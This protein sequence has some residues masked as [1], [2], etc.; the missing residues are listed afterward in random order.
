MG[1]AGILTELQ[2]LARRH[3]AARPPGQ[4]G[5][6]TAEIDHLR[7]RR[8]VTEAA[9][10]FPMD[11]ARPITQRTGDGSRRGVGLQNGA[12]SAR[13]GENDVAGGRRR[14]KPTAAGVERV[15]NVEQ[16]DTTGDRGVAGKGIGGGKPERT[17]IP[18]ETE[19]E[20]GRTGGIGVTE[21]GWQAP[22]TVVRTATDGQSTRAGTNESHG[23]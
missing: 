6:D 1:I 9:V 17:L 19:G 7:G 4:R 11:L 21:D 23:S 3:K 5:A 15:G 2:F 12:V 16:E 8:V 13:S 10:S 14:K 22:D 20:T 18:A